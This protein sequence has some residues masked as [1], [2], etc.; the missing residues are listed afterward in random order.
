MIEVLKEEINKFLKEIQG[1][2]NKQCDKIKKSPKEIQE[3]TNRLRNLIN[4]T[5]NQT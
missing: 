4:L 5:K 3:N 2:T 1:N